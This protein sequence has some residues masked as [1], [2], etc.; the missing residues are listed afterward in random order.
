MTV[1]MILVN[2]DK[3][4]VVDA[5]LTSFVETEVNKVLGRFESQLTRV[6]VYLSDL[7]GNKPG[8]LDKRCQLEARP[9]GDGPVSVSAEADTVELSVRDAVNKMKRLLESLFGRAQK[10]A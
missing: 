3:N 7:N 6:E 9:A 5:T 1:M 2:S 10:R 4:V 8:L